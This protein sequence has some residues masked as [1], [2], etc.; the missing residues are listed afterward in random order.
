MPLFRA[1]PILVLCA[2]KSIPTT[3]IAIATKA[4]E[5]VFR[6]R[7]NQCARPRMINLGKDDKEKGSGY[8]V[9]GCNIEV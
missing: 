8:A 5:A 1:T 3:L 2:P 7:V 4:V 9:Y 6:F